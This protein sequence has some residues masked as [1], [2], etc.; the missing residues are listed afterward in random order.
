MRFILI[1]LIYL[2][3]FSLSGCANSEPVRENGIIPLLV[4]SS[5]VSGAQDVTYG[6]QT[7]K[8]TF[9]QNI[10][11]ADKDAV[12]LNGM[13]LTDVDAAF[14]ELKI[15]VQLMHTTTYVLQILSTAIKGPTGIYAEAMTITFNTISEPQQYIQTDL[16]TTNASAQAKNVYGFLR[17]NFGKKSISGTMANVSWN[18]NEAEWVY[19]HTGK[20][21]A[22]N[23]FDLIHL[24]AS[25]ASWINYNDT[26]VI[27]DWWNA[28]G[29]VTLMWHWNVP[30]NEGSSNHHFYT[31]DTQFDI[32]KAVIEGTYEHKIVSADLEKAANVLLLL[33]DKNIPVLWRPLHEAAGKWFW[34]GAKDASYYKKLWI[35]MF[36]YFKSRG[37]NNLI[38]VWTSETNDED[39]YP[40]NAYVDIIGCDLYNRPT[41]SSVSTIYNY[42]NA[43]FPNKIIALS[44]F[45]TLSDFTP[46]WESG[47]TWSWIMPWYDYD[48]TVDARSNSFNEKSH[49][50]ANIEY[51]NRLWSNEY[52]LTRDQ[53][54]NLK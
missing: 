48:R 4:S 25:P 53:M 40:G 3:Q 18:T 21:P 45:G 12:L 16:V 7:I 23:G 38:W 13:K 35:M 44:E 37:L 50:H 52:V 6:L 9:D 36:N 49:M 19:K 15:N 31:K 22:L 51:W 24:Y 5:I 46:Q 2:S 43:K 39:W 41:S 30:A 54:P 42:I 14:K 29:L 27:E 26:K 34:W 20:Y 32:S 10:I 1:L 11:L 28:N 8:L 47:S 17:E 33:K